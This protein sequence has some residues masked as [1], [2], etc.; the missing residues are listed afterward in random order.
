[1]LPTHRSPQQCQTARHWEQWQ[2]FVRDQ[3]MTGKISVHWTDTDSEVA[4]LMTKAMKKESNYIPFRNV[5]LN[6][7]A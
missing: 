1:M 7:R 3:Y 6:H 4:D 2:Q 5:A